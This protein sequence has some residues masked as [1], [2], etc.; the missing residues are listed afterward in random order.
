[1]LAI[2][3]IASGTP[4]SA[5]STSAAPTLSTAVKK[6][7]T[8]YKGTTAKKFTATKC[9][10]GW[11][12]KKPVT[13]AGT[14][15]VSLNA[16]YKGNLTMLWSASDVKATELTGTTTDAGA[17]GLTTITATGAS[18]PQSQCAAITGDGVLGSGANTLKFKVD[19]STKGC[20]ADS[21]APSNVMVTGT[22]TVT[23]G[24]GKFVGATGT[25]TVKGGFYV[26]STAAG[27]KDTQ[28]FNATFT[29]NIK[30][31]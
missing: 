8:C 19:P 18:A 29:G 12:P 28:A 5:V 20:A 30:L 2:G 25:L 6:Q 15:T 10:K 16:T 13:K 27:T 31:K 23:G 7:I 21:A 9:P 3:L 4:A 24:T 14:K 1:M 11:S 17:F 26:K 22:A